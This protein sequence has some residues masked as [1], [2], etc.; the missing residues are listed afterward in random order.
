MSPARSRT[1]TRRT[2]PAAPRLAEPDRGLRPVPEPAGAARTPGPTAWTPW[3]SRPA[4]G[5][6]AEHAAG[7]PTP[8]PASADWIDYV[9]RDLL[10]WG[11]ALRHDDE[12]WT[13]SASGRRA[14]HR[15]SRRRSRW[16]SRARRSSLTPYALLGLVC[17]PRSQPDRP[18][19]RLVPGRRRPPTGSPT[20]AATTRSS[21][22]WSPT[23]A[24]GPWSGRPAAASPPPPRSTRWPGRRRP[25][26]TWSARSSRCCAAAGSSVSPTTRSWCR[27]W[28]RSLAARARTSP[29]RSAS[30][31]ARRSSCWSP[32]SAAPTSANASSAAAAC[33]DVDAHDVYRGAVAVMMRIVFLLFAEERR[34]LPADNDLY[35]RRT[36]RAGSAPSWSSAPSTAA[37]R[38]W[39][40]APAPGTGCWPCSA[41]CTTASTT[42]G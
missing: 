29:R 33:S 20:C 36:R 18:G 11:D 24:S 39:S 5:C 19:R 17:P 38:T 14:R 16:S 6:A 32:R 10:G 8:P 28:T 2:A 23:A 7:R 26:A 42:R 34:L 37:R 12:A 27:C 31:S 13:P 22:A 40:T 15:R 9:L 1:G 35:A 41:P 4:S 30:R 3:T 25:N 21:W